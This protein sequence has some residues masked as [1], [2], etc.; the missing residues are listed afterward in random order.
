MRMQLKLAIA[1][2]LAAAP[3]YADTG[4]VS[5]IQVYA[6]SDHTQVISPVVS[7]SADLSSDTSVSLGYLADA[8]T[9]ASVDIVSQAS[10][11]TIHDTRHQVSASATQ[12]VGS[13]TARGGYS[14]SKENDYLSHT[15]N[16]SAEQELDEK[17]TTLALGYAIS[18][19]TV[20]R[21]EDENFSRGLTVQSGSLGLTQ[22]ISPRLIAQLTY[23]LGYASGYQASPYRFVPVRMAADAAPEMWVPETDPDTRWR[24]ALVVGVNRAVGEAS[25][26]QGDYRIYHD[27]W[28]I[29]SH[30]IGARLFTHLTPDLELRVRNRFYTQ[31]AATFY[32]SV[33]TTT[34]QFMAYDRELSPL[35]SDTIGVKLSYQFAS[36]VE[37]EFKLD[38]FY[39]SYADFVPLTSRTG[40]NVGTGIAITY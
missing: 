25:S 7:A 27:T 39:Y 18:L 22:I 31:N 6:D 30:T 33:Y 9:S 14:F 5:K 40:A 21:A 23:E 35:W 36:H 4:F 3:A 8:V 26:L 15:L 11:T 34:A 10:A 12:K 2:V 13:L 20:G 1:F 16:A 29:T 37:A 19:N 24:H 17:N 32:Q 28:G 38:V